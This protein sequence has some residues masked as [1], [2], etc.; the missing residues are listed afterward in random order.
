MKRIVRLAGL[1]VMVCAGFAFAGNPGDGTIGG[2]PNGWFYF[3]DK[4]VRRASLDQ[5]TGKH[6]PALK[7]VP[8]LYGKAVHLVMA[9]KIVVVDFWATWCGPCLASHYVRA[10]THCRNEQACL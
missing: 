9:G 3:G 2:F 8:S 1:A 6:A 10:Q 5:L 4:P 7:I